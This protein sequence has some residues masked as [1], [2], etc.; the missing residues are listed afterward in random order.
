VMRNA[1][2][3]PVMEKAM[4]VFTQAGRKELAEKLM[5]DSRRQVIELVA[6]G[7]EKA[8]NGDYRGAVAFMAEAVN[9]LPDNPQVVFNAA[10]AALKCL[11][12]LGWEDALGQQAHSLIE[13]ARILDPTNPR[14]TPLADLYQDMLKKYGIRASHSAESSMPISEN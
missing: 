7:A 2:N 9:K 10:L 14:L 8:K 5:Q 3:G 6:A 11:D 1:P 13:R 12:N 4:R